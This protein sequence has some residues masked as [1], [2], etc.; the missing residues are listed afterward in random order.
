ML[1]DYFKFTV[2]CFSDLLSLLQISCWMGQ[3]QALLI[4]FI[5]GSTKTFLGIT[6]NSVYHVI[7]C[8]FTNV[9]PML[10]LVLNTLFSQSVT[11][12]Q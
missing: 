3:I 2:C 1:Y 6:D 7:P 10:H 12:S 4:F 9:L 8:V 5:S 11:V